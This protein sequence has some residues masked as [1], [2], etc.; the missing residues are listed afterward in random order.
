MVSLQSE[1]V[2]LCVAFITDAM[3]SI[4]ILRKLAFL[5]T[6]RVTD[7]SPASLAILLGVSVQDFQFASE[8][9][10][11]EHACFSI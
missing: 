1:V 7:G 10:L 2:H 11:A 9:C 6:A 5:V 8:G 4:V 3:E